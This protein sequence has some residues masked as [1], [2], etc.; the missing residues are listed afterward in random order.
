MRC[1][2]CFREFAPDE[3][4]FA[5]LKKMRD[6][7]P[8]ADPIERAAF[9]ESLT[10]DQV[11]VCRDCAPWYGDHPIPVAAIEADPDGGLAR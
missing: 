7:P 1:F 4:R 3:D 11:F 9:L 6:V 10:Y 8:E 5:V 2:D